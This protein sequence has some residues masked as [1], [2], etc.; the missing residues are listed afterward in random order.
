MRC[1]IIF[2]EEIW[3]EKKNILNEGV[4]RSLKGLLKSNSKRKT[5]E[6]YART[7]HLHTH[8]ILDQ[9]PDY[10]TSLPLMIAEG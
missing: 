8:P 9:H 3:S 5:S 10:Q 2:K 1:T 4:G 7:S 6:L